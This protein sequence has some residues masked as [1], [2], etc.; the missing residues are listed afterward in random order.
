MTLWK[1]ILV[2]ITS[3]ASGNKYKHMWTNIGDDKIWE[4]KIFKLLDI[5]IDNE[6]QFD[7]HISN[8]CITAKKNLLW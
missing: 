6:L 4:S 7:M 1:W 8:V 5:T 3:F 2:I